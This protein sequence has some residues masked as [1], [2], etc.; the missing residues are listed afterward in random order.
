MV[1][2]GW[3]YESVPM[4]LTLYTLG[5]SELNCCGGGFNVAIDVE[6]VDMLDEFVGVLF[7]GV[8]FVVVLFVD[9]PFAD[10][11]AT[12]SWTLGVEMPVTTTNIST[13]D[14]VSTTLPFI[15]QP[16]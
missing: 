5:S 7:V 13:N 9:V 2:S 8:L 16:Q 11:C 3:A 1:S 10:N 6:F 14:K 12:A 15:L 4:K